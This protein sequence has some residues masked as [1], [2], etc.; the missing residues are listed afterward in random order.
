MRLYVD[1]ANV[2]FEVSRNPEPKTDDGGRQKVDH[3]TQLP[4]WATQ[5]YALD[6]EGGEMLIVSVPS[7]S[8]PEVT[9][10]QLVAPVGLEALPWTTERNGK[11]RSGVAFR[12]REL[13]PVA[14]SGKS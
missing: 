5:L 10:G 9:V 2:K 13:R 11:T 1:T 12:A 8:K 6:T 4:V 7:V 3:K 14:T